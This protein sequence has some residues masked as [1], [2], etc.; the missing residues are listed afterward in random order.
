MTAGD[1]TDGGN[2]L[3]YYTMK[4]HKTEQFIGEKIIPLGEPEQKLLAPYLEGKTAKQ[5]VFSPKTAMQEWYAEVFR[6]LDS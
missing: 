1:I 4:A 2:G 5:A 3:W 6:L